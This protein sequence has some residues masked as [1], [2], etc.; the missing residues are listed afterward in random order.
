M[1][2]KPRY[3]GDLQDGFELCEDVPYPIR[4]I[5]LPELPSNNYETKPIIPWVEP[6][7]DRLSL[8]IMRGCGRG[9]RFCSA[10]W[11]YRPVRERSV[12]DICNEV[13]L[14]SVRTG[15]EEIGLL[16]LSTS[17]YSNLRPLLARLNSLV[18][19]EVI[20]ISVPSLR[21]DGI[22]SAA[23]S[24]LSKVRKSSMTFA[25]EAGTERLR[26][27]INKQFDEG[28]LFDTITAVFSAGWRTVKLYF[29]VGL[30][31]ETDEDILGIAD[32]C[33]RAYSI[34]K[35]YRAQ[36]NVSISPFIPKGHTPFAWEAQAS[37]NEID[38]KYRILRNEIP[39]RVKLT[40]RD[41]YLARIEAVLSRS[42]RRIGKALLE[43]W[44][45]GGGY[46]AWNESFN[47]DAWFEAFEK[48]DI[49]TEWFADEQ[50]PERIAPWEI[51][52]KGIPKQFLLAEK[53]KAYRVEYS[54]SCSEREGCEA[55]G[56]CDFTPVGKA[57]QPDYIIPGN[58]AFGRRAKKVRK[59][60]SA[61]NTTLRLRYS[62]NLSLRWLGHLDI[63]RAISRAIRR[64]RL[65]IAYSEGHHRHQKISYGPPLPVGYA[66]RAEYMDIEFDN[67]IRLDDIN[68]LET[69]LPDGLAIID[70]RPLMRKTASICAATDSALFS[71]EIP[72][73]L[74]PDFP[75]MWE[76]LS[77]SEIPFERRKKTV[78][79]KSFLKHYQIIDLDNHWL[80]RILLQC[81]SN[82]AGRPDEYLRALGIL[83][84]E[85]LVLPLVREEL[86]IG[87]GEGYFNPMGQKWSYWEENI[88][89]EPNDDRL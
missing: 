55:C 1:F 39:N 2:Y 25:P 52:D 62:R 29:M 35:R 89:K 24:I 79:L 50:K 76:A 26:A 12:E 31:T 53:A 66:S 74:A 60:S 84:A 72:R 20:S 70:N 75:A 46:D 71:V 83:K 67:T 21:P 36:L 59:S 57:L 9:C 69:E 54:P 88:V 85:V 18:E 73:G 32:L 33:R 4:S 47:S 61:G 49:R 65:N 56:I 68:D 63:T 37:P 13:L 44:R 82:G 42:D 5:E 86:L 14:L 77:Q 78:N 34:S 10:G 87:R 8:E 38:R 81:D 40:T 3:E 27:V 23:I 6:V 30:P 80:L 7:H 43:I 28:K 45:T 19:N 58:G 51:V 22:D 48:A 16:S 11:I 41:P 15:Y 17:D 64:S